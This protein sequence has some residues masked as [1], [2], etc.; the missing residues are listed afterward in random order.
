MSPSSA[1]FGTLAAS[2]TWPPGS[3]WRSS[4]V[5]CV[6]GAG[7]ADRRLQPARPGADHEHPL[8]VLRI[9][10][11]RAGPE[12]RTGFAAGARVLD[13]PQPAVQPHPAD[14]LLVARQAQADLLGRP[15]PRLGREL[16]V[17]DLAAH[18]A[19]EVAVALGERPLGLQRVLEPADADDGQL[20][21]LAHRRR[22][23]QGVARRHVHRRLDHEQRRRG[24]PDRRVDV[25]DLP[26]RLDEPGDLD[27]L[28]DRRAALDQ[29]V[30][31]QPHA[32]REAVADH[33]AHGGDDLEQEPRPVGQR[34]RRSRRCAGSSPA[35]G[36]RARSRSGCTAARCRRS[37][38]RRSARRRWRSRR[39]SRR[40]RSRSPPWGPRGTA[41]RR[42]ATAPTP[43]AGCTSTTPARRCG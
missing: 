39:R 17:G 43:A 26:G 7:A 27:G 42:P 25:V 14:A 10:P 40:S 3:A 35:T 31:A 6:P 5:T 1:R 34:R 33:A 15:G 13:A 21:R 28:V 32:E 11:D 20:D 41:G 30:A 38:P 22:D 8:A 24:H 36:S 29:L 9:R 12:G 16:G 19:D 37:P 23:E 18:D 2:R 4:T